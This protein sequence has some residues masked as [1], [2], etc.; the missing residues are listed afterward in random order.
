MPPHPSVSGGK[1]VLVGLGVALVGAV[2]VITVYIP[3]YSDFEPAKKRR[4]EVCMLYVVCQAPSGMTIRVS[5][6]SSLYSLN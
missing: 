1:A 3:Y 5:L 4:D 6:T 2:G